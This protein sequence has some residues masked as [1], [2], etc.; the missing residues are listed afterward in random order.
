VNRLIHLLI[1]LQAAAAALVP[2]LSSRLLGFFH[3]NSG[4]DL[5]F[6]T[7]L[8]LLP[9]YLLRHEWR[10]RGG[11]CRICCEECSCRVG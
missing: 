4:A 10:R 3:A 8:L 7:L 6:P 1:S 2:S 9:P 11:I 5:P